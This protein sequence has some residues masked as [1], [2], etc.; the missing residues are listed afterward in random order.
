MWIGSKVNLKEEDQQFGAWLRAVAPLSSHKTV[1]CFDGFD[2]NMT[3]VMVDADIS[4]KFDK[5]FIFT[6]R[7]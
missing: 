5:A 2:S 7:I 4:L 6:I 3:Y 1:F